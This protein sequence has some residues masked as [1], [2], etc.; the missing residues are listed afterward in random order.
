MR[1]Y[2][3]FAIILSLGLLSPT[4]AAAEKTRTLR[5]PNGQVIVAL[6]LATDDTPQYAVSYRG[7]P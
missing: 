1:R 2:R 4:A 5:S 7:A 3:F 6:S